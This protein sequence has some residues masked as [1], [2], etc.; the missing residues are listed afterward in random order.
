[1]Y[2]LFW[3][4][5]FLA[6]LFATVVA[7][8]GPDPI[9]TIASALANLGIWTVLAYGSTNLLVIDG[10]EQIVVGSTVLPYLLGIWA[11]L[12]VVPLFVGIMEWYEDETDSNDTTGLQEQLDM[13]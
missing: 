4:A 7:Y 6:G 11:F 3:K 1:M 5:L 2:E 10:G 12:S 9:A 13:S 8:W